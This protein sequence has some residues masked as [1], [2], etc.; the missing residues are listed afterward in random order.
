M[1]NE[2]QRNEK[3]IRWQ[4][5]LYKNFT[6]FKNLSDPFQFVI[7]STA[8]TKS[9]YRFVF[10]LVITFITYRLSIAHKLSS[11]NKC[12]VSF[13]LDTVFSFHLFMVKR[14][15]LHGSMSKDTLVIISSVNS[16]HQ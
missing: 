11:G 5:N 8:V 7:D 3:S 16:S 15:V 2:V 1:I 4:E 13:N 12:D 9:Y 6:L 10:V 14:V